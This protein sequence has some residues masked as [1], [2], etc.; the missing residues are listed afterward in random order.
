MLVEHGW[1]V[2]KCWRI[3]LQAFIFVLNLERWFRF[4]DFCSPFHLYYWKLRDLRFILLLDF[5]VAG[6]DIAPKIAAFLQCWQVWIRHK[7]SWMNSAIHLVLMVAFKVVL[8]S[9]M[10]NLWKAMV[11][12][13]T[14]NSTC[15]IGYSLRRRGSV[16]TCCTLLTPVCIVNEQA[17]ND[18]MLYWPWYEEYF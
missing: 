18:S 15:G 2:L 13:K 11:V 5:L 10:C 14:M 17:V 8:L 1:K 12:M 9:N 6:E 3:V 4:P 7:F 16:N